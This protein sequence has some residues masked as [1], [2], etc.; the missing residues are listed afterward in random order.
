LCGWQYTHH[1]LRAI[2]EYKGVDFEQLTDVSFR[3]GGPV[4]KLRLATNDGE[5]RVSRRVDFSYQVAFDRSFNIPRCHLCVNHS[6]FLADIVVGDAWLPATV[7]TRTGISLVICRTQASRALVGELEADGRVIAN[8]VSVDE[9]TES[10]THRVAF[11]DFAYAYQDYLRRRGLHHPVMTA[12]NRPG[13]ILVD[14]ET[15]DR[16]HHEL[17]H[18]LRLQAER[19]YRRLWWRKLLIEL[20]HLL[21]RYFAWFLVRVLRVKS[22]SGR[23]KEVA[24]RQ[25]RIFR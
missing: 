20:P 3:G 6:N 1:A 14:E 4:G 19:R 10:Q 16:F 18:K 25:M 15:V 23:R 12:P 17:T 13:A 9:I 5:K 2:C 21:R 7:Y 22:L 11:G 24:R 8:E